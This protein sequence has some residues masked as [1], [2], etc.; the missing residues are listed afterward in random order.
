MSVLKA[1]YPSLKEFEKDLY[2]LIRF[3]SKLLQFYPLFFM[4]VKEFAFVINI[5]NVSINILNASITSGI[6]KTI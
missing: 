1:T 6:T 3:I 5:V 4:M 2:S